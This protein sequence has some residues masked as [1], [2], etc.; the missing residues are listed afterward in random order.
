MNLW[1]LTWVMKWIVEVPF[2]RRNYNGNPLDKVVVGWYDG[3]SCKNPPFKR[4]QN[5]ISIREMW[6]KCAL[7][8]RT[9][10]FNNLIDVRK[11]LKKDWRQVVVNNN[12]NATKWVK[13]QFTD[14]FE[15]GSVGSGNYQL[16]VKSMHKKVLKGTKWMPRR[17][18]PMKDVEDCDKLRVAVNKLLSGDLRMGKPSMSNVMLS[19]SE[20]I[21]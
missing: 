8:V 2:Y 21:G 5:Y 17:I 7:D 4:R 1:R 3:L 10:L 6:A 15:W 14:F 19:L 18:L 20:Y 13:R 16:L 9:Q 12:Y 11:F